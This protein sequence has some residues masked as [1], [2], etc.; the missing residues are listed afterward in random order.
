MNLFFESSPWLLAATLVV[1]AGLTYWTYR[2]TTP[3]LNSE[4]RLF[5]G[6]LRFL[7]LALILFLLLEP[8]IRQLNE[9]TEP[10]LLAVLVDDSQSM[11]LVST[12]NDSASASTA[13]S[14]LRPVLSSITEDLDEGTSQSFAFD[15][16]LRAVSALDSL[17][18]AGSRTNIGA[19]LE[20]LPAETQNENLRGVVLISDGQYNAGQTPLRVADRYPV[21]IHTVTVGDTAHQR[22]LQVR[23]IATNDVGYTDSEVP[24]R[25]TLQDERVDEQPVRVALYAG[26]SLVAETNVRL[27]GGTAEVPV[28][29]SF[30]PQTPGRRQL[31]VRVS[32]VPGEA[33]T[34]NNT[35]S[36]SLRVL[37]RK[38]QVLLLGAAPS[39]AFTA[40]RRVLDANADTRVTA[41]VPRRDGSF[42]G[43]P[44]PDTLDRYD[45]IVAAGFPSDPVPPETTQRV[46]DVLSDGMPTLFFLDRQTDVA[47]WTEAFGARLPARPPDAALQWTSGPMQLGARARSHP[48]FETDASLDLFAELPPLQIPAAPWSPTPDAE[49]LATAQSE[50]APDGAPLLILRE[51]AGRRTAMLL[52]T[53]TERWTRLPPSLSAAD[54]LW[55]DLVSNLVRWTTT[56]TQDRQARVRP[57]ASRFEGDEPVEFEGQVYDESMTPVSSAA[58]EVTVSDSTGTEYSYVMD[59][60]G[61]G[62]YELDVGSL[63]EGT[64]NYR[65]VARRSGSAVGRDQGTFSVGALQI[66]Y[67]ATRADPVLMRQIAERSGGRAYRPSSLS[68]FA[69]DLASS[70]SFTAEVASNP[71]ETELWRQWPF[72]A[73]LLL[74]LA[75]EWT[76]RKRLGL[77]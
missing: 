10:P 41:R 48:I 8:V 64:Y 23:R 11:Q 77:S 17:A 25:A 52:A 46:A 14:S 73:L 74:L 20:Q 53:G 66:E 70:S 60:A 34:R 51:R 35:R 7:S 19:A 6:G 36:T 33:T 27:P 22:D 49:V 40:V 57:V 65:A 69:S 5:L 47:T 76:L 55:S 15:Q 72:L 42:Y 1:A 30:R 71:T 45:A 9:S 29:L 50:A 75:T 39:P 31:S 54:P 18:F 4:W 3:A 13:R 63:P 44:F 28:D 67:Q 12:E 61:N 43:G 62:Q 2:E 68:T 21:P 38:R 32:S 56:Q 26:D 16:D 59:P 58:V 37:D 24:V